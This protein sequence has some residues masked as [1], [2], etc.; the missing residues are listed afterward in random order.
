MPRFLASTIVLAV[1][2]TAAAAS[3]KPPPT[4][5][6]PEQALLDGLEATRAAIT[7][8]GTAQP[9]SAQA[10]TASKPSDPDQGDDHASDVAILKVCNHDNPSA[11]HSAICPQPNSPP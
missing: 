9:A 7:M 10:Q 8:E 5:K 1:L 2:T 11:Q 6:A 3:A 4:P